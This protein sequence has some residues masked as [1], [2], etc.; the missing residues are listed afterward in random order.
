MRY[1]TIAITLDTKDNS[2]SSVLQE[3]SSSQQ[4]TMFVIQSTDLLR[5]KEIEGIQLVKIWSEFIKI[6]E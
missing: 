6:L 5:G 4:A 3:H 2:L 1:Y